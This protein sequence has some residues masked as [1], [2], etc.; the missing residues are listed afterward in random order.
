ME[1]RGQAELVIILECELFRE[2][3]GRKQCHQGTPGRGTP[4]REKEEAFL[5]KVAGCRRTEKTCMRTEGGRR[6]SRELLGKRMFSNRNISKAY[7]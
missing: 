6:V 1:E 2:P 4:L 3:L 5:V 7:L